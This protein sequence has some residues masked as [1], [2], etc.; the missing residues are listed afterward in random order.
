[1]AWRSQADREPTMYLTMEVRWFF[2]GA[3]PGQL[4][5]WLDRFRRLPAAQPPRV[6]HY[7]RLPGQPTLGIK[8]REGH[9]EVKTRMGDS[10]EVE[11][12]PRVAGWLALWR[13]WRF[14]LASA[15]AGGASTTLANGAVPI[16]RWL[17]PPSAWI[18]V[19]KA[20]RLQR[21]RLAPGGMVAAV[22]LGA[23][24]GLGCEFELSRV[25]VAGQAWWS[26][27]F[28]AFGPEADL[29]RAL[30][31]TAA[32]VLGAGWPLSLDVGH[33]LGYPAWLARFEAQATSPN[34]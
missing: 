2:P 20:R 18:A 9:V 3:L 5:D 11:M 29:E 17:V 34:H 10:R 14:P 16:E 15:A 8:L 32:E 1:M 12:G 27:C 31:A 30:L 21:Y 33:S 19:E 25:R 7:L 28:E 23:P 13:K 4:L 26:A 6:D 24:T 22:P